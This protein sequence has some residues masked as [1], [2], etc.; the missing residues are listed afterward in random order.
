MSNTKLWAITIMGAAIGWVVFQA[1]PALQPVLIALVAACLLNPLVEYTEK[2]LKIKKWFAISI[3]STIIIVIVVALSNVILSLIVSQATELINEYQSISEDF[4]HVIADGFLYL[5][6]VGFSPTML[7]ELKQ[8]VA[9]LISWLGNFLKSVI[10]S[11]LGSILN[12]VDLILALSMIIYFLASGKE[13]TQYIVAH[14]PK[15]LR[16]TT[17]N[18]IEGTDLVIWSYIKMQA[19]I[20]LIV[21]VLS[22]IVFML[23]G[24]KFSVLLGVLA[25]VL[26]FIPYFGSILAGILA[27]MIALLTSGFSQA[28]ITLVAVLI[29]QQTEG[30]FIM[31]RL[32]G[33]SS[34][35]HPAV[36]IIVILI[37][38]YF[39]GTIGMFIAVPLFGLA[40]L[41]VAEAAKLIEQIE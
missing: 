34:G 6:K 30:N 5:E 39:W 22:T 35:M 31:P 40:R 28:V 21:G 8:Y 11:G 18:L 4:N 9:Q 36:I 37:G 23:I 1:A 17:V 13:M 27:T 14:M 10:I 29:I 38:N 24:V 32:Q 12:G 33:K 2:K 20:A 25:G 19:L 3:I 16:Q 15:V 26:N 7:G 41:V